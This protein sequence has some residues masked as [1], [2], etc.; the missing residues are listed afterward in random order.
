MP[1][2][3]GIA[4]TRSYMKAAEDSGMTAQEQKT[5]IEILS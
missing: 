5:V 2:L 1:P 3:H 4:E